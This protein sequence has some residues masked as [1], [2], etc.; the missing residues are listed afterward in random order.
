MNDMLRTV[1]TSGTGRRAAIPGHDVAGKTGTSQE[2]RDAWF[3]GYSAHLVAGVWVGND[4][5]TPT[6]RV[7]GGS[8][9]ASIWKDVM[10]PAHRAL[11][12][13][14]LPGDLGPS[15]DGYPVAGGVSHPGFMQVLQGMFGRS[16]AVEPAPV[17]GAIPG[18]PPTT[19]EQQRNRQRLKDLLDSR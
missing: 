3:I 17:R 4:D 12:P 8:L 13:E 19:R 15:S 9:P 1:V 14:P 2:Y 6:K 5:N 10:E 7:T 11:A 18:P 16:A